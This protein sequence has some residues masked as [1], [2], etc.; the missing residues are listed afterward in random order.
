M[1]FGQKVLPKLMPTRNW[2]IY[3][4][5]AALWEMLRFYLA[6]RANRKYKVRVCQRSSAVKLD[7]RFSLRLLPAFIAPR[8]ALFPCALRLVPYA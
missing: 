2:V 3:D 8:L 4:S 5:F 6:G 1:P 7:F